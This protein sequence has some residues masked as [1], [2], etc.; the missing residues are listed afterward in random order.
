MSLEGQTWQKIQECF[1]GQKC[2]RCGRPAVRL[3][4][5]R[6]YCERHF[7]YR[8]SQ[9]GEKRVYRHPTGRLPRPDRP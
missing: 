2:C 7:P 5:R 6:F 4:R 9:P 8:E 3:V 1:A